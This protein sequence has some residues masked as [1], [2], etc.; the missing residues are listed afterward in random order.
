MAFGSSSAGT[1]A[2]GMARDAG[3]PVATTTPAPAA[4][5]CGMPEVCV[6]CELR[7]WPRSAVQ[8]IMIIRVL[9]PALSPLRPALRLA[10]PARPVVGLHGHGV[11]RAAAR[12]LCAAPY[13][14][15]APARL[16]RPGG[17]HRPDPAS[18]G[19]AT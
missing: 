9:A 10:G 4:S 11:A 7:R 17:P 5:A 2:G 19:K 14:A 12:G 3:V 8:G 1:R 18:V 13:T 15:A 6:P 16:G